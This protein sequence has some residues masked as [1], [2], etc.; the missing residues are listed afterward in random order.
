MAK[1]R[2]CRAHLL[3]DAAILIAIALTQLI[4]HTL[5]NV[6]Y[7][8]RRDELATIADSCCLAWGR[9]ACRP[10]TPLLA[11]AIPTFD[12]ASDPASRGPTCGRTSDGSAGSPSCSFL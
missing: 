7:G 6:S 12:R 2:G 4:F 10:V 1:F 9:A 5:T 3:T 8:F 11:R